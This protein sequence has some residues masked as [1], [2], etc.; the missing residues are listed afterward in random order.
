MKIT[1]EEALSAYLKH[2]LSINA[3]YISSHEMEDARNWIK[4]TYSKLHTVDT[5]SRAWRLLRE[6][7]KVKVREE[8][9]PG[10]KETTW[11]IIEVGNNAPHRLRLS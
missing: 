8:K 2:R 6:K 10:R 7:G 1:T 3:N 4:S 9:I 11:K 5:I